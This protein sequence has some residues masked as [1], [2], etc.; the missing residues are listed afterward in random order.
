MFTAVLIPLWIRPRGSEGFHSEAFIPLTIGA[1]I[2]LWCVRDFYVKG[3]GTLGPWDPPAHLVSTGL[4]KY[5]RNPM[6]I[7]VTLLLIGWAMGFR[8]QTL[9]VYAG[10]MA[11]MFHVRVVFFEERYLAKTHGEAFTRYKAKVPRWV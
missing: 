5:S 11:M 6:Y 8:S 3:K 9:W 4:Y 10:V 1:L 7:A 2:L